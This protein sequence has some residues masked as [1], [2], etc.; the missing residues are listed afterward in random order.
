MN[1]Q[2]P[3]TYAPALFLIDTERQI[4]API[5]PGIAPLPPSSGLRWVAHHFRR[6][7]PALV[8]T[9]A[10]ALAVAWHA[11]L[12]DGSTEPLWL[13]GLLTALS[14]AAGVI[15]AAK[16]HGSSTTMTAAFGAGAAFGLIGIAAWTP[17]W[18]VRLLMLLLG[19]AAAY[20]VCVPHWRRDRQEKT[21]HEQAVEMEH[22]KGFNAW[23]ETATQAAAVV[24]V[25]HSVERTET[26]R[27]ESIVAAS[28][29]RLSEAVEA[30]QRRALAPGQELDI[31]ALLRAAGHGQGAAPVEECAED[32]PAPDD[33]M[34]IEA[35]LWATSEAPHEPS[36]AEREGQRH[37]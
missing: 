32:A 10:W 33:D 4:T 3:P 6:I 19:V 36:A 21:R 5:Q 26:A 15:A 25:A 13:M 14:G 28:N 2:T 37:R 35:L 22:V 20:G 11:E 34:D 18:A 9:A 8:T 16:Q 23:R 1:E 17:H 29:A 31:A 27:V 24:E 7:A 30:H 12:P